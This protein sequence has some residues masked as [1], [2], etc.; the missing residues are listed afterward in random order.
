MLHDIKVDWKKPYGYCL[1][2][3]YAN[4]AKLTGMEYPDA[5]LYRS[6]EI[7]HKSLYFSTDNRAMDEKMINRF[8][9][10]FPG[11]SIYEK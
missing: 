3:L 9:N 10:K 7:P 2:T 4:V 8:E 11:K 5:K 6:A 1:K